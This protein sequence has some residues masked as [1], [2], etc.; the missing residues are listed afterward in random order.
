MQHGHGHAA[1]TLTGCMNVDIQLRH[2][3]VGWTWTCSTHIDMQNQHGHAATTRTLMLTYSN[4]MDMQHWCGHAVYVDVDIQHQHGHAA[5]TWK[6]RI[7]TEMQHLKIK[8]KDNLSSEYTWFKFNFMTFWFWWICRFFIYY[9]KIL[10][11]VISL[12]TLAERGGGCYI[13]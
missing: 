11:L 4:N 8:C 5:L 2:G 3:Q 12:A 13:A 9:F 1:Q 7:N 10:L 6:C